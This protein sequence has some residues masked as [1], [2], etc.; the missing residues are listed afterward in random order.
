MQKRLLIAHLFVQL[1]TTK[2]I[3]NFVL[4]LSICFGDLSK[5]TIFDT[6]K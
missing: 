6:I 1:I 5:I 3:E 2:S 4:V